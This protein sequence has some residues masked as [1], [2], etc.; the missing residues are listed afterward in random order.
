MGNKQTGDKGEAVAERFLR[1][2]GFQ[3]LHQ[4]YRIGHLELDLVC[5][6]PDGQFL[7]FVEV[8][9]RQ[10]LQFGHPAEAL[11]AVK[12][13]RLIRAAALYLDQKKME[14]VKCRFDVVSIVMQQGEAIQIE[15]FEDAFWAN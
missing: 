12:R 15:H 14:E 2:K 11:H 3:V 10:N 5:Q 1:Q 8:K 6:S 13:D 9:T 7:V 4:N